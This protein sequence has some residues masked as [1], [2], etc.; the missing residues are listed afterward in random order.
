MVLQPM[1]DAGYAAW[2]DE[3]IRD[4]AAEKVRAGQWAEGESLALARQSFDS[5]LPQGLATPGHRLFH[6]VD[7]HGSAVGMLWIAEQEQA[8]RRIAYVYDV[9]VFPEHRRRGHAAR[10]FALLEEKARELGLQGIGLHV[11]G[12]NREALALYRKLGFTE[13][14]IHMAKPLA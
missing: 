5:L 9:M 1:D 3:S 12:H 10:A 4:Y 2:T 7:E 13:T 14:S 6:M 11:F 8:G